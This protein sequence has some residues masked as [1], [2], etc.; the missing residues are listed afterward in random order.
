MKL[1]LEHDDGKVEIFQQVSDAFVSVR[2]RRP[3][4]AG[5]GVVTYLVETR[6]FS[7]GSDLRELAK[8]LRQALIEIDDVLADRLAAQRQ[9]QA[10]GGGS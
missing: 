5:D 4:S 1:T 7:W 3:S 6:S 8:E 9:G 2:Q 10:G